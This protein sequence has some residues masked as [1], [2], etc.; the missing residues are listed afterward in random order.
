[1]KGSIDGDEKTLAPTAA[2]KNESTTRH[3]HE[4]SDSFIPTSNSSDFNMSSSSRYNIVQPG[5]DDDDDDY[6][7]TDFPQTDYS[8]APPFSP[9][10]LSSPSINN[11]CD[12]DNDE[13]DI[14]SSNNIFD[15]SNIIHTNITHDTYVRIRAVVLFSL[16]TILLFAD[17]NLMSPN[18]TA[19]AHDFGFTDLQRDTKLGG[20]IALAFFVVG[21]PAAYVVGILADSSRFQ[22]VRLFAAVVGLGEGACALTFFTSSYW[23]LYFC[24]AITGFSMG[25]ALPLIYSI[26]G[27]MYPA[28]QRHFVSSLV[29]IGTGMGIALGQGIAGFLGPI[30]GWRLPFLVISIPAL[31]CAAA[32]LFTVDEPERG[33]M[34]QAVRDKPQVC[35]DVA[36]ES[37]PP[38]RDDDKACE[39]SPGP[40]SVELAPLDVDDVPLLLTRRRS[41]HSVE[42]SQT[43]LTQVAGDVILTVDDVDDDDDAGDKHCGD[44]FCRLIRSPTVVLALIQGAPGCVPWGVANTYLNDF[45]SEN[46]HMSIQKR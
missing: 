16:T 34:E 24:R 12:D 41:S 1:M 44:T 18:L 19:M 46:R 14:D 31:L 23:Q 32:V 10:P 2:F 21:A 20:D 11:T 42:T 26:L 8:N 15:N 28:E 38:Q 4:G 7:D 45:L 3:C 22:R 37:S 43:D 36:E 27:D 35:E 5:N 39:T 40:S 29:G 13:N 30:Y 6:D 33:C 17:Q 9:R 25:G